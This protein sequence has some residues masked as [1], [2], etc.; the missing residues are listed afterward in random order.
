MSESSQIENKALASLIASG[1]GA[2]TLAILICAA[3]A[4][5][6]AKAFLNFY[7]PVGP[8]SGKTILAVAAYFLSWIILT[9][10]FSKKNIDENIS[11]KITFA[12]LALGLLFSF[13]PVYMMLE[14]H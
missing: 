6:K 5:P 1:V 9:L 2:L 7:N 8:L 11:L 12:L 10:F 3:E 13:P 14:S 4:S